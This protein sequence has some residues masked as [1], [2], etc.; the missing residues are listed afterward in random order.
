[1]RAQGASVRGLAGAGHVSARSRGQK[2]R[3][4][5]GSSRTKGHFGQQKHAPM[6]ER[7]S[8]SAHGGGRVHFCGPRKC[9]RSPPGPLFAP[10]RL[11]PGP[12]MARLCARWGG[13]WSGLCARPPSG[14]LFG[15]REVSTTGA[16]STFGPPNTPAGSTNGPFVRTVGRL[17]GRFVRTAGTGSTFRPPEVR[18]ATA[19]STFARRGDVGARSCHP[20][21]PS[22]RGSR[23]KAP[24]G[25]RCLGRKRSSVRGV[26]RTDRGFRG[27]KRALTS[28]RTDR[29]FGNK[30]HA[31]TN[32]TPEEPRTDEPHK[33][34]SRH[35]RIMQPPAPWTPAWAQ[36]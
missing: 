34:R 20:K 33:R 9:A 24:V 7:P 11:P 18:T 36:H 25:A 14:P 31:P 2:S 22:V 10:R 19:G 8:K 26:S 28:A 16:G 29:D 6:T 35:T 12:Q 17:F 30:K 32:P 1:M 27:K 15:H 5:R 21:R 23:A 4:V 3:S 13:F